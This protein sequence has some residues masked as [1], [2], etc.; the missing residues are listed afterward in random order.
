MRLLLATERVDINS[1]DSYG[2]TAIS[3]A[4]R[5]GHE[6]VV[7]LLLATEKVNVDLKGSTGTRDH[8]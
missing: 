6:A 3:W 8:G 7:K 2:R 5:N 1:N 4:S